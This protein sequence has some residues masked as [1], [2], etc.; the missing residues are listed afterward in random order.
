MQDELETMRERKVW[1]L[2]PKPDNI[3]ILGSRWVFN[4]KRNEFGQIERYK[5][6]LVALGNSQKKG[7]TYDE[8]FSPVIN[9][10]IIRFFFALLVSYN[11]WCNLQC[12]VRCAYLYAPLNQKILM[13]Q[14]PGFV[15]D[16]NKVCKLNKAIYG[17]HQSGRE[18]FFEIN[19]KLQGLG[20]EK[21]LW[22]NCAYKLGNNIVLLLYVDDIVLFGR[23]NTEINRAV[24]LLK[25]HFDLK[26]LGKTK[27]LLGVNFIEGNNEI[28]IHQ[29]DYIEKICNKYEKFKYPIT[30]L[31]IAKGTVYSKKQ[32][33]QSQA[34]KEEMEKI[35][36]RNV[37]GCLSFLA[38][39]TRPDIAYA[40]NIFSQY[41]Q[42]PGMAH[43]QGLLKLLGYVK[44]T[45]SLKLNIS[46]LKELKLT[47]Y[48]DAD[49]ANNKDD[50]TSMGGQIIFLDKVPIEW[51]SFKQKTVA[52]STMESEFVS[53]TEA[54]K[55]LVWI[56]RILDECKES[57]I[58]L[59]D[60]P[61]NILMVDN[62]ASI[63]F[64][65]SPIENYRT[66]HI[67]VKL[68]F[69]RD[70]VYKNMFDLQ[71][72]QSKSNL[73]DVFTKPLTKIELQRFKDEI[74]ENR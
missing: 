42:D 32:C 12:D 56:K 30:S 62:Q 25:K 59:Q 27:K 24:N 26:I 64:V 47:A 44:Y 58:I 16:E 72:V 55:E 22:C 70:L 48:S 46:N 68:F 21:F 5:A 50:R 4:I 2:I 54:A 14:P 29:S 73:A 60:I 37:I 23:S 33:P 7:E 74:F 8:V 35:P 57:N 3:K 45:Q 1:D 41:Q 39:R 53:L 63:D 69:V 13:K 15:T 52:L 17:L 43:W 61:E 18:W 19:N 9:F 71:H 51:R 40:T 66:K 31:P 20:F 49:Y 10:G 38:S 67:D 6:R 65:K 11:K 28:L 36:Y 34:E